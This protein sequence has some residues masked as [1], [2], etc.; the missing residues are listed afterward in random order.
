M[1][2][3]FKKVF[4]NDYGRAALNLLSDQALCNSV[5]GIRSHENYA[6]LQGQKDFVTI[7]KKLANS[8][9][10]QIKKYLKESKVKELNALE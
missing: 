4:D 10:E 1:F 5:V 6:Y 7:I 8:T 3:I 2:Y 9:D